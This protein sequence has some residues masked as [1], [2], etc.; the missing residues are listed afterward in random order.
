MNKLEQAV[1][2][3]LAEDRHPNAKHP[4]PRDYVDAHIAVA[5]YQKALR[6]ELRFPLG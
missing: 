2:E 1:A 5:A 6:R 4:Q 3:A